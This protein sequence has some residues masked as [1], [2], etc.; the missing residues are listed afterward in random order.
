MADEP[1][2]AEN[3][4]TREC[5]LCGLITDESVVVCPEDGSALITRKPDPLVGTVVGGKFHVQS[6]IGSGGMGNVYR[7]LHQQVG[8]VVALKVLHSEKLHQNA[9]VLRFQQEAKAA[10]ALSHPNIVGFFDYGL[11]EDN[12]PY[13]VMDY[14]EG[15]PLDEVIKVET[16]SIERCINIFSQACDAMEHAH[17]KGI[18][19][20]DIKPSNL[21]LTKKEDGSET[22][23]ILD[24]GIAKLLPHMDGERVKVTQTGEVFGSPQYMSPEQC[25]GGQL[26]ARS[27]I[28]SLGCVMYEAL[29]GRP[30]LRGDTIIEMVYNLTHEL[31][32]PF[33]TARPELELPQ[34]L[35]AVVRKA[36]EK[37][38]DMR[39]PSMAVLRR[40]LEFIHVFA[41]HE[42]KIAADAKP[43]HA[44][45]VFFEKHQ[46]Q[47]S[48]AIPVLIATTITG[49]GV[50]YFL[51]SDI[52]GSFL[53]EARGKAQIA[54]LEFSEG[55]HSARL[56]QPMRRMRDELTKEGKHRDAFNYAL[57]A[58]SL[59]KESEPNSLDEAMDVL[60]AA[61]VLIQQ[62]DDRAREYLLQARDKLRRI[63][64]LNREQKRWQENL[65]IDERVSDIDKLLAESDD[66]EGIKDR[67]TRA[68]DLRF[69]S[70]VE[71]AAGEYETLV[72]LK[73]KLSTQQRA[74]LYT[75]LNAVADEYAIRGLT[76]KAENAYKQAIILASEVFGT[77]SLE[78]LKLERAL[79]LFYQKTSRF[80]S[81]EQILQEALAEANTTLGPDNE[82]SIGILEDL[83]KLYTDMKEFKT[84][85]EMR[86]LAESLRTQSR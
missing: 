38:P 69:A 55:S 75:A 56:L 33:K 6:L 16:L 53:W 22:L 59:A 14:I 64:A 79:G 12:V 9:S 45:Q 73:S 68:Q 48:W 28:Y 57:S 17:Q 80:T 36:L 67:F 44:V 60:A 24:F 42:K 76:E 15:M 84:A 34:Q 78:V 46:K 83:A 62:K 18:I 81:A 2:L 77:G 61:N 47:L 72:G 21:M 19:H 25:S 32:A 4:V 70:G 1:K 85:D 58:I 30:P 10:A 35:E 41:E 43:P 13:I 52:G 54:W 82:L 5:V 50:W 40:N 39:F 71:K 74:E 66:I 3:K 23:K 65:E 29:V 11:T 27:D 49:G 86:K 7:A 31:P 51:N 63:A 8:R 26:D 37:D 20:R